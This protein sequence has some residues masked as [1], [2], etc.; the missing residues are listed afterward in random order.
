[1]STFPRILKNLGAILT[2]RLLSILEQVVLP[3]I[4][5]HR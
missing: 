2:G 5:I 1:M 3:P 4:F